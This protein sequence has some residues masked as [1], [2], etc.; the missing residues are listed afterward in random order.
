MYKYSIRIVINN[1][2][3]FSNLIN[4]AI[5]LF[6]LNNITYILVKYDVSK[7]SVLVVKLYYKLELYKNLRHQKTTCTYGYP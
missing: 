1:K 7:F 2:S 6:Y 3:F 5:L 4:T